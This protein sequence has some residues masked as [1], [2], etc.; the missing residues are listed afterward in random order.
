MVESTMDWNDLASSELPTLGGASERSNWNLNLSQLQVAG[1]SLLHGA[2]A[3]YS[4]F[5]GGVQGGTA[6]P[7]ATA[8]MQQTSQPPTNHRPLE[9]LDDA[10]QRHEHEI[11]VSIIQRATE[12]T[13][14]STAAA[15]EAQLQAAWEADRAVWAKELVG[16]RSLGGAAATS[17]APHRSNNNTG[18]LAA[19]LFRSPGPSPHPRFHLGA[20]LVETSKPDTALVQAHWKVV[21]QMG[22][23]RIADTI[24][25]FSRIA[26]T[27]S[28]SRNSSAILGYASAWQL[29]ANLVQVPHSPVDQAKAAL[30]HFCKQ[31]QVVVTN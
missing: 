3:Q 17:N 29:T 5:A 4:Q 9:S 11:L 21:Q 16:T 30:S 31:F 7:F 14:Q 27:A 12:E 8:P 15:I 22:K 23:E 1:E 18:L 26:D 20:A 19:S 6:A 28:P 25:Q 10:I 2:N 13:R 24:E